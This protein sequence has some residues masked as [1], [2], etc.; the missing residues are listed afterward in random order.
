VRADK[1]RGWRTGWRSVSSV[2]SGDGKRLSY[3][4]PGGRT[5][6]STFDAIDRVKTTSDGV[7]EIAECAW[8]GPGYRELRRACGNGT[9][10]SYLDD[11]GA[12][13]VGYDGVKRAIRQ[14]CF[15]PDGVTAFL[16]REY[17]YNRA[18]V[19]QSEKRNDDHA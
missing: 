5:L 13:D 7:G 16:D 1:R 2:W 4:Y 6:T 14:R 17:T 10:L 19:R 12:A 18:D 8:I 15:L 3:T 11:G 9:T